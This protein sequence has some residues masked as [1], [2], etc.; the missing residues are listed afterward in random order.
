M[1]SNLLGDR[2]AKTICL[3][4]QSAKNITCLLLE[5]NTIKYADSKEI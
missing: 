3:E 2:T 5:K 4:L 1:T